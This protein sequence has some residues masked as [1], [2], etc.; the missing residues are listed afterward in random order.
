MDNIEIFALFRRYKSMGLIVLLSGPPGAGQSALIRAVHSARIDLV[1]RMEGAKLHL[2]TDRTPMPG[3]R[4]DAK[5][6]FRTPQE[7]E[8][9]SSS[10]FFRFKFHGHR[11][12]YSLR[13]MEGISAKDGAISLEKV[14]P[15]LIP[16]LTETFTGKGINFRTVFLTPFS[17]KELTD[18]YISGG[19]EKVKEMV[20]GRTRE[21]ILAGL[22]KPP[23]E[24]KLIYIDNSALAAYNAIRVAD[25]F[26]DIL[27]NPF[28]PAR[29]KTEDPFTW[30]GPK[31]LVAF[32]EILEGR[33]S[34]VTESNWPGHLF[35][36]EGKQG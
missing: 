22:K 35:R 3:E 12:A 21:G 31:A 10:D 24:K 14:D 36:P 6:R 19:I 34:P 9:L 2:Y 13:Q 28:D 5:F 15:S 18:F 7:M 32:I 29:K 8:R 20:T 4:A 26:T 33:H 23:T 25:T 27:H 11:A 1:R 17:G 16:P 30:T